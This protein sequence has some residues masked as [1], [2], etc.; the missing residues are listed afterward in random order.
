MPSP[1]C[2][3]PAPTR[4][5]VGTSPSDLGPTKCGTYYYLYVILDIFS[6]S[7]VGWLIAD[8]E[9]GALAELLIAETCAKQQIDRDQL[10]LH[11]DNGGPMIAK[12]VALLMSDLGVAPSHSR[13]HVSNDTL[14]AFSEAQF[15]TLKYQPNFPERFGSLLEAR[16]GPDNFLPGTTPNITTVAS[17]S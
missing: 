7:V 16:P 11:A 15:K 10:T 12:P 1:N 3:P 5:G 8:R 13:P 9:S 2:W 4:S 17:G 14:R 6:R